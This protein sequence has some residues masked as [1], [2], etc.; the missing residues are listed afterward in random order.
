MYLT[1]RE[2][3]KELTREE[4]FRF[5]TLLAYVFSNFELAV[6]YY[7]DGLLGDEMIEGYTRGILPLFEVPAVVEWWGREGQGMYSQDLCDLVSKQAVG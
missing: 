3:P 4:L 7:R 5:Q 6:E 2:R 1:A